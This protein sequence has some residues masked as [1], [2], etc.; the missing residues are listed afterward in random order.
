MFVI[1]KKKYLMYIAT[2]CYTENLFS[3]HHYQQAD[4]WCLRFFF[5]A[6]INHYT[7]NINHLVFGQS[8]NGD[9]WWDLHQSKQKQQ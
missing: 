3:L 9:D 7:L 1:I 4:Q 2:I 5:Q 8:R 6:K